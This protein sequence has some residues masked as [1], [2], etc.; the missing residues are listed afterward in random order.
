MNKVAYYKEEILKLAGVE[1]GYTAFKTKDDKL[2]DEYINLHK[3]RNEARQQDDID[4]EYDLED[5]I[6][7]LRKKLQRASPVD[8]GYPRWSE[9][10]LA[11]IPIM[12]SQPV[13]VMEGKGK[14]VLSI[15][16]GDATY[17][18][19][20]DL[21]IGN[22]EHA[23]EMI[24]LLDNV[25]N[26]EL[27]DE[28]LLFDRD[29]YNESVRKENELRERVNKIKEADKDRYKT[30]SDRNRE[31]WDTKNQAKKTSLFQI[32]ARANLKKRKKELESE[33]ADLRS[34]LRPVPQELTDELNQLR[35]SIYRGSDR[36]VIQLYKDSIQNA[37]NDGVE[38]FEWRWY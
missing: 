18:S 38:V 14:G 35:D 9:K 30:I 20:S 26:K 17:G 7:E 12:S 4:R 32:S 1:F 29:R 5:E 10:V 11:D 13:G 15:L 25:A 24:N 22:R 23:Q 27:A 33:I 19:G 8:Y 37:L 36:D 28:E 34:Q 16:D 6:D 31:L 3:L 21:F 2:L